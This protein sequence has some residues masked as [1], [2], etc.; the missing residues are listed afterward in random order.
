MDTYEITIGQMVEGK[1]THKDSIAFAC[2]PTAEALLVELHARIPFAISG[3]IACLTKVQCWLNEIEITPPDENV[4]T[5]LIGTG[6]QDFLYDHRYDIP[7]ACHSYANLNYV[8][9][10]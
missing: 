7:R 9:S 6:E 8:S 10:V 4:S 3:N 2:I 5:L 1:G